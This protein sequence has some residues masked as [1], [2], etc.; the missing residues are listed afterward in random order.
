MGDPV[1]IA[2][3]AKGQ[4]AAGGTVMLVEPFAE[5]DKE[6][7][8][9]APMAKV[10]YGASTFVCTP[11]SLSQE[12]GRAMGSQAGEPGMAA[13]FEEAGYSQFRRATETPF[14]IIYEARA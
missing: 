6:A 2:K 5:D 8:L 7:N 11:N 4:H 3:H 10:S 13:V 9:D 12:V 14:N 1:G